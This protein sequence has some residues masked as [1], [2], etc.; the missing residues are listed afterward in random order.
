MIRRSPNDKERGDILPPSLP[1]PAV[2]FVVLSG[3][4][5]AVINGII[6]SLPAA[7][8]K[9][10]PLPR[11][12]FTLILLLEQR[13]APR[14]TRA[15]C[16]MVTISPYPLFHSSFESRRKIRVIQPK[17]WLQIAFPFLFPFKFFPETSPLLLRSERLIIIRLIIFARTSC[18]K[19]VVKS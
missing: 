9:Q 5:V 18:K 13:V 15:M 3:W 4:N 17:K 10:S 11:P 7:R 8:H 6:P 12:R 14:M 19:R 2:V 1:H 16:F